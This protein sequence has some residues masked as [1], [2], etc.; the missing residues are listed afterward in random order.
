[1]IVRLIPIYPAANLATFEESLTFGHPKRPFWTL[2]VPKRDMIW[3]EIYAH[4]FC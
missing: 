2:V 4:Q 1:M 3:Y